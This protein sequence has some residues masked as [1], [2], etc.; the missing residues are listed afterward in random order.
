VGNNY[1]RQAITFGA[2]ASR[3]ISNSGQVNFSQ[4]SGPWGTITH[5]AVMSASSSGNVLAVGQLTT[6]KSVVSGNTPSVAI[7]EVD[8]LFQTLGTKGT[9]ENISDYLANKILDFAFRNQ[10]FTQPST[11][12]GLW[13]ATLA[14]ASTGATA[15]ECSGNSYARK[16]VNV[17][18]GS[19]PTWK[20]AA[21]Q[22]VE[23]LHDITMA[24]PSGTW[25]T[26]V[27]MAILD[28]SSSGNILFYDNTNVVDQAVA[29][30]DTVRFAANGLDCSL[31]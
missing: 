24:T 27:S 18:G 13:T 17:N 20:L 31:T 1:S 6:S 3:Q 10:T 11:Y 2:A 15:G 28:A 21:S 4:A 22:I 12:V 29:A 30:N 8:I 23:N 19:S 26:V 5:F 25:G 14:D 9:G 16:Q 7:G